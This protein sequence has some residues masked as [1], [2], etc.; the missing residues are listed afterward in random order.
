MVEPAYEIVQVS[1]QAEGMGDLKV[2]LT[3]MDLQ[4]QLRDGLPYDCM[5]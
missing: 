5:T 4:Q 1:A 3:L 2:R